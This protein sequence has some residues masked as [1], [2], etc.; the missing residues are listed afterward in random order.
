M[1]ERQGID[2]LTDMLKGNINRMCVTDELTELENMYDYA[3]YRLEKLFSIRYMELR[4]KETN[5]DRN[6]NG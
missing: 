3:R 1:N 2:S 6:N 5:N 4:N